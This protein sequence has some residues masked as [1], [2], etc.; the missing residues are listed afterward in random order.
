V[1]YEKIAGLDTQIG[2]TFAGVAQL[3]NAGI[4]LAEREAGNGSLGVK[5]PKNSPETAAIGATALPDKL[6]GLRIR[7]FLGDPV[8][9]GLTLQRIPQVYRHEIS[10]LKRNPGGKRTGIKGIQRSQHLF[11]TVQPKPPSG[12]QIWR[13]FQ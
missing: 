1:G 13:S 4:E 11:H 2:D 6:V 12:W 3:V 5:A 10:L 9:A 8:H 7:D